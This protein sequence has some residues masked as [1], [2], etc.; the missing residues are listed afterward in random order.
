MLEEERAII[1]KELERLDRSIASSI[2]CKYIGRASGDKEYERTNHE[3]AIVDGG[4]FYGISQVLRILG[5][6]TIPMDD[7]TYKVVDC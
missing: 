7:G 3:R 6:E 2:E 4:I 1:A 5:Y